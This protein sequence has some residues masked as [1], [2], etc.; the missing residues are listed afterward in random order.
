MKKSLIAFISLVLWFGFNIAFVT[1][2]L[3]VQ[4]TNF[5]CMYETDFIASRIATASAV[6]TDAVSGKIPN[7]SK[8]PFS[9]VAAKEVLSI[10]LEPSEK[11]RFQP[12]DFKSEVIPRKSE[13]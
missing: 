9:E 5:P 2:K 11:T 3:S 1:D 4:I 6:N 8:D 7:L 13:R 12:L 10:V